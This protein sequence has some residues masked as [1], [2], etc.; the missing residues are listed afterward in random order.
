ME[1]SKLSLTTSA[2]I[3]A[4]FIGESE[5]S[6]M[7]TEGEDVKFEKEMANP[8]KFYGDV[9]SGDQR[10]QM[11]AECSLDLDAKESL[12]EQKKDVEDKRDDGYD[13]NPADYKRDYRCDKNS[14]EGQI[15]FKVIIIHFISKKPI[16][17]F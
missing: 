4:E 17:R 7:A 3:G 14:I 12:D 11:V 5:E 8:W 15:V 9:C 13:R 16:K 2:T 1:N 10:P 6:S